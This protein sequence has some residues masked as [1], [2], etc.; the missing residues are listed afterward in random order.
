MNA[1]TSMSWK[2]HPQNVEACFSTLG[3]LAKK[4]IEVSK[5]LTLPVRKDAV[6]LPNSIGAL[7]GSLVHGQISPRESRNYERIYWRHQSHGRLARIWVQFGWLDKK[8]KINDD[9]RRKVSTHFVTVE[10]LGR[11]TLASPARRPNKSS[12]P[13]EK[14]TRTDTLPSAT[15]RSEVVRMN[16]NAHR[17]QI[18]LRQWSRT[19]RVCF[20]ICSNSLFGRICGESML[21]Q[22]RLIPTFSWR[23]SYVHCL[24]NSKN[25][26]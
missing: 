10:E 23:F 24:S 5:P 2:C 15:S 20:F 8:K 6:L 1:V 25:K 14:R 11:V 12:A 9:F 18:N 19:I 3:L 4:L 17:L 22:S 7:Y 26:K 16:E 21:C 13:K